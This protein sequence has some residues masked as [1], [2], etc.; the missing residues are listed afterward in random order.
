M[1]KAWG[2]GGNTATAWGQGGIAPGRARHQPNHHQQTFFFFSQK[3]YKQNIHTH[4]LGLHATFRFIQIILRTKTPMIF[5]FL[6]PKQLTLF[7][8]HASMT[9]CPMNDKRMP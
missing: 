2:K 8:K 6:S 5:F 9:Y 3:L 1:R 7:K 4:T